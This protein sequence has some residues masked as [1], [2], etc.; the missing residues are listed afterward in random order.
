[1]NVYKRLIAQLNPNRYHG[2]RIQNAFFEGWYFKVVSPDLKHVLAIIPGV[3][4]SEKGDHRFSFVML[5]DGQ[6]HTAHLAR[7]P[8][9]S[10]SS[11]RSRFEI[12]MGPN[13]F[14]KN[15]I[16]LDLRDKE[17]PIAGT[18]LLEDLVPWPVTLRSPGIMG[19]YGYMPFMECFHGVVSMDH[20]VQGSLEI[21][22]NSLS[23]DGG[24]GY[25]EK[26]WGRAFPSSW[27]WTQ[28]N[29]FETPGISLSLS[30]A[31]I[32][33]LGRSFGGL[34]A[35]LWAENRLHRFATYTG[36]RVQELTVSDHHV[37]ITLSDRK[38]ELSVAVQRGP[39]TTLWAPDQDDMKPRVEETL[40]AEL[41]FCLKD[42]NHGRIIQES[43]GK[44]AG[45]EVQG[46]MQ[47]LS[48]LARHRGS[49]I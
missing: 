15:R 35:G 28:C 31:V 38:Y 41:Y 27:V 30:C 49:W 3:F 14:A 47:A 44:R 5:L 46:D 16:H 2:H 29:H 4:M 40:A 25:T 22:G 45:L 34:I 8:I 43:T 13:Q 42:R 36:A 6:S 9:E 12:S 48:H 18:L 39:T 17:I 19:W 24:R 10:F 37:N 33:F 32:P 26:D 23:F 11:S 7:Y 21:G 20:S 1:M